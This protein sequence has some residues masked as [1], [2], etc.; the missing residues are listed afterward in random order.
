MNPTPPTH[1]PPTQPPSATDPVIGRPARAWVGRRSEVSSP[2]ADDAFDALTDL[3]M[4]EASSTKG[5]ASAA[6][7]A[8]PGDPGHTVPASSIA[9]PRPV[10]RL[11]G[12]GDD[13]PA[14]IAPMPAAPPPSQVPRVERELGEP[15]VE[16]LSLSNLPVLA[17]AWASQYVREISAAAGR[18]VAVL[19]VQAGFGSVEVI[20]EWAG[21]AGPLGV[22]PVDDLGMA[23]RIAAGITD[24][25]II[26]CSGAEQRDLA[27]RGLIR[28]LTVLTGADEA[29]A[30]AAMQAVDTLRPGLPEDGGPLLRLAVMGVVDEGS[31]SA[32][33][34]LAQAAESHLGRPVQQVVCSSKI[35]SARAPASLF[36]GA[37]AQELPAIVE[38]LEGVL[39]I[40]SV[41]TQA[42]PE[43]AVL[44]EASAVTLVLPS[45]QVST[46][47][48]EV[49]PVVA[50]VTD[51]P[52]ARMTDSDWEP[53][54]PS[55]ASAPLSNEELDDVPL[56]EAPVVT[57]FVSTSE[58]KP[59]TEDRVS[60]VAVGPS[61]MPWLGE[62]TTSSATDAAPGPTSSVE[63]PT[64]QAPWMPGPIPHAVAPA[65]STPTPGPERADLWK[66][67]PGLS[68]TTIRCPYAEGVEFGVDDSG[69]LHLLAR[70]A[71]AASQDS[72]L[73]D[74]L[75]AASWASAH[76]AFLGARAR[77]QRPVMH[78]FTDQPKRSR[79]LLDTDVRVHVLAPVSIGSQTAWYCAELN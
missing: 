11:A 71:T 7:I 27:G 48:T 61:L 49:E 15:V 35:R 74:L 34:S 9:A 55:I 16:C 42:A 6:G 75:V 66:F 47:R 18:P 26:R 21:E 56:P 20:G 31:I 2:V 32:G 13:E 37:V 40:R 24:R 59:A 23:L 60:T 70:A 22:E 29:A 38:L 36:S 76:A 4:G 58:A 5:P 79:R 19:R 43:P 68:G 45:R 72:A 64:P 54:L 69:S 28:V 63:A 52:L 12:G 53:E 73:A 50:A 1:R 14:A 25:W 67:V 51:E 65:D 46:P 77:P 17:S 57:A 44:D 78:V 10:L 8:T 3:F 33:R 41:V 39:G 30:A 62:H